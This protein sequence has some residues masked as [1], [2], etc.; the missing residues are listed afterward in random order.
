VAPDD[1]QR[2]RGLGLGPGGAP[3]GG[4]QL[5]RGPAPRV[6]PARGAGRIQRL[7]AGTGL[8]GIS[9]RRRGVEGREGHALRRRRPG[10]GL[11]QARKRRLAAAD[12]IPPGRHLRARRRRGSDRPAASRPTGCARPRTATSSSRAGTPAASVPPRSGTRG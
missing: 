4:S 12:E 11:G 3:Q 8:R 5:L 9:Q 7:H 1:A 10:H 6:L 2:G